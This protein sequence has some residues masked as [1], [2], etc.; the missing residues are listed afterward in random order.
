MLGSLFRLI[1]RLDYTLFTGRIPEGTFG[2]TG[3]VVPPRNPDALASAPNR[4]LEDA[5]LG[6]RMGKAG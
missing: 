4:A 3:L 6:I 2:E 5:T 1:L